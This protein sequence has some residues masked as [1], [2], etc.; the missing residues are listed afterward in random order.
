MPLPYSVFNIN[1]P[2]SLEAIGAAIGSYATPEAAQSDLFFNA[3]RGMDYLINQYRRSTGDYFADPFQ[4]MSRGRM[5]AITAAAANPVAIT[6]DEAG[7]QISTPIKWSDREALNAELTQGLQERGRNYQLASRDLLLPP[8]GA[9]NYESIQEKR[10]NLTGTSD[11]F[12]DIR[13]RNPSALQ[14]QEATD[15]MLQRRDPTGKGEGKVTP[16]TDLHQ[17][18]F[19]PRFQ[20]TLK[21]DPTKAKKLY[22]AITG[23]RSFDT[24]RE[25]TVAQ[26]EL[27]IKADDEILADLRKTGK[28]NPILGT[29]TKMATVAD[30]MGGPGAT[31]QVE[32]PISDVEEAALRRNGGALEALRVSPSQ[33]PPAMEVPKAWGLTKS[34]ERDFRNAV[35]EDQ[36]KHPNKPLNESRRDA[37]K[38]LNELQKRNREIESPNT[39]SAPGSV[40]GQPGDKSFGPNIFDVMRTSDFTEPVVNA[41]RTFPNLFRKLAGAMYPGYELPPEA[42]KL[43]VT[44]MTQAE[45][46]AAITAAKDREARR[47][48]QRQPGPINPAFPVMAWR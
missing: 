37:Y 46:D 29:F 26:R 1:Q 43:D 21:R 9:E 24:D 47:T 13:D 14:P 41:A 25:A 11:L 32:R 5:A 48:R 10:A 19:D 6:K 2:T 38:T 7:K 17:I 18:A 3:P 12:R 4:D 36:S 34:E 45:A 33:V 23:G 40:P 31:K 42:T 27:D 15:V 16:A 30:I 8:P 22:S 28:W 44:K 20:E 35:F 39:A